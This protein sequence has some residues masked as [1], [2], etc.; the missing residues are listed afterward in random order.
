LLFDGFDSHCTREFLETLED[1][2]IIP[3]RLPPHTSHFLQPLDVGPFQ[4]YKH[5]HAEAVDAATRTGC[6]SFNKVEFLAAIDSIRYHTFK[7][8]TILKG[9]RETGLYPPSLPVLHANIDRESPTILPSATQSETPPETSSRMPSLE[10]LPI[11]TPTYV[12]TLQHYNIKLLKRC[13]GNPDL[14]RVQRSAERLVV[15]GD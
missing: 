2:R 14:E 11:R 9:W 15:A 8:H 4:P 3:Y 12:Q 13:S 1:N 10:S 6:T 7:R 5:W